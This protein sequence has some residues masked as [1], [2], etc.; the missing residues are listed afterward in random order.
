MTLSKI[1]APKYPCGAGGEKRG[2]EILC[3]FCGNTVILLN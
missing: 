3:G 1:C 2:I